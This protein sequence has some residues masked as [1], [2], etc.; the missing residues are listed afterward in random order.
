M[1][2]ERLSLLHLILVS[3]DGLLNGGHHNGVRP[4]RRPN[5][6]SRHTKGIQDSIRIQGREATP[7]PYASTAGG[8]PI[9]YPRP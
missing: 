9:P 8:M 2:H 5:H 7:I 1:T 6:H 4:S 3:I